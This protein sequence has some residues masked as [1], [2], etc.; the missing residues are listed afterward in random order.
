MIRRRLVRT[1]RSVEQFFRD[2]QRVLPSPQPV[3]HARRGG[4]PECRPRIARRPGVHIGGARKRVEDLSANLL[5][6]ILGELRFA[7]EEFRFVRR[8][9]GSHLH[10]IFACR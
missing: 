1:V 5:Q 9:V 8:F 6:R 4:R 7:L 10:S 2:R 3:D